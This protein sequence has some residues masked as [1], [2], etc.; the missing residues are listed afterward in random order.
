[1]RHVCSESHERM[2]AN[3]WR[4]T[5]QTSLESLRRGG[6]GEGETNERRSDTWQCER[7]LLEGSCEVQRSG[8]GGGQT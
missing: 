5:V 1:M 8:R 3:N 6:E 4:L 7:E 2:R